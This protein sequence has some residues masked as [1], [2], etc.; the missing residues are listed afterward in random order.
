M[1]YS[2]FIADV[3]GVMTVHALTHLHFAAYFRSINGNAF[4]AMAG[5]AI[6][7]SLCMCNNGD[8]AE[9]YK[10]GLSAE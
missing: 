7:L 4:I 2:A 8:M 6:I 3:K 5:G 9:I 10:V 1:A